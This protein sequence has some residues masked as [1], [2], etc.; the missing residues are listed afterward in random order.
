MKNP[1]TQVV[2]DGQVVTTIEVRFGQA[3]SILN[4][5]QHQF[6]LKLSHIRESTLQ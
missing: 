4:P 6:K 3:F 1:F 5:M 2:G